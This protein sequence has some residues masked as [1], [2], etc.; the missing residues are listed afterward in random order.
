MDCLSSF[1]GESGC[2]GHTVIVAPL[3]EKKYL[4]CGTQKQLSGMSQIWSVAE[5]L[6]HGSASSHTSLPPGGFPCVGSF[7]V[8][9][10]VLTISMFY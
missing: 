9:T 4:M 10:V 7:S 1:P 5:C 8:S 3:L 6:C 2:Q